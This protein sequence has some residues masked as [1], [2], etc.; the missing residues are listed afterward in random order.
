M[1]QPV[2]QQAADRIRAARDAQVV[3]VDTERVREAP[4]LQFDL[5]T[6]QEVCSKQL[7]LDVQET[8]D[9]AQA[10]YETYKAT[11]YPRSDSGYLPESM[12][13]E[14]PTVLN[15]LVK[16]DPSLRTLIER[17]NRQQR[18]RAWNDGKVSAHHGI[19]PTLEPANLSAMNE[20]ELAV[21]RVIRAHYLAQFLPHHEFDRTVAQ[22][23]C[24]SQSLAAV[25]KQIAVSGWREVLATPG[26]D[27]ADGEDAQR[28]QVLPALHAGLS[29]PVSKVDL[30]ALKTLPPKPYTQGEL[31]KAMKT[32]AKFVTDPRL[33]QKLRD[34]TGIGTEATRANIING[35][36][37][38][39]Y[40]VKKGRAVRA[41]DAAFTLI[42]AVPSAIADP[43]TTAV[44]EQALDM[45][46]A[47]QMAL[48]TFIEKQSVWVGQLV[49][50]YRGA[51][52]SLK[53]PPAPACPQCGAPMQQRT[54]KSGAFWS[55]SRYPDCKGT[56]PIESPTGRRS[57]PRKRRA[58]SRAS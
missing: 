43:G 6:L 28:S 10:L 8:L 18:S 23:S 5:G 16:T 30:K 9:I 14:V 4:P 52:L 12:L 13:A 19:I 42:D 33:K 3:S 34:T 36:I 37:G 38:R 40:L 58:A 46:E 22:F 39:G 45:I 35:L 44:W 50:Q 11:T 53:L 54:G 27:D 41:S 26:P 24:G 29:C 15:S 55:C 57:A 21:Y 2:A 56:L 17:L 25:G 48:D 20:K 7:G 1:Q 31:I 51:T 32:V 47:G 49:Q